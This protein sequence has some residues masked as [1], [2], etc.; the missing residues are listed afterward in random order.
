[1]HKLIM[2][3][4]HSAILRITI[5]VQIVMMTLAW[6]AISQ[7]KGTAKAL[8]PWEI[9]LGKKG[10]PNTDTASFTWTPV[11]SF[12]YPSNE[13]IPATLVIG[14]G[15]SIVWSVSVHEFHIGKIL[16]TCPIIAIIQT[17]HGYS[18]VVIAGMLRAKTDIRDEL[19]SDRYR[20]E[21]VREIKAG[22]SISAFCVMGDNHTSVL[23]I[24]STKDRKPLF[25]AFE[26]KMGP[27]DC[28]SAIETWRKVIEHIQHSGGSR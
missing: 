27:K 4:N 7:G 22:Q 12:K 13:K 8:M 1:M 20:I 3:F 28:A 24:E 14:G 26:N 9:S 11:K 17:D 21:T 5:V 16:V 6:A 10:I 19:N 23:S 18:M 15:K 25:A 2:L